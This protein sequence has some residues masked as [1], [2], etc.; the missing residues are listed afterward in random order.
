ML[1]PLT[2]DRT[3][4]LQQ[5][6][7]DQLRDLIETGGLAAGQRMPSTRALAE[8]YAVSRMTVV[9]TYERLIAAGLLHTTPSGGTFVGIGP[10]AACV[11]RPGPAECAVREA[12][13][14][15]GP[16]GQP[17][18][19]LFPTARWRA[20]LRSAAGRFGTFGAAAGLAGHPAVQTTLAKWLRGA[21]GLD[22]APEQVLVLPSRQQALEIV[23]HLLL[24]PGRVV[25]CES[26][27]DDIAASLWAAHGARIVALPV[28][29]DGLV[30]NRL[31]PDP[32]AL[33]Y[34]TPGY[35]Y[36]LGVKLSAE[37]RRDLI[38]WAQAGGGYVVEADRVGDLRYDHERPRA[39]M[40]EHT[41][42]RVLHIGDF[43][44]VL[45]PWMTTAY[46]LVPPHLAAAAQAAARMLEARASGIELHVLAEFVENGGYARHLPRLRREYAARR[47]AL[48]SALRGRFGVCEPLGAAAGFTFAW[49]PDP[50]LG[51][52]DRIVAEAEECG[53]PVEWLPDAPDVLLVGFAH[54]TEEQIVQRVAGTA[55]RLRHRLVGAAPAHYGHTAF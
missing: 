38:G 31:P 3:K 20:L 43:A 11:A 17:D 10:G 46:L 21:R 54:L 23:A 12:A 2:L 5:Q 18:P 55:K 22:A 15:D 44:G 33:A 16:T 24:R 9:L 25:A 28:D 13:D 52:L 4:P 42:G 51:P 19:A 49:A 30:T 32:E 6:L 29:R 48:L 1:L 34:V 39:L 50:S 26:P 41:G 47:D 45:G 14:R 35:Q 8:Q 37:R 53:L 7:H 27:G 40:G 36:P